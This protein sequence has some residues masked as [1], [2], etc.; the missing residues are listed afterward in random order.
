MHFWKKSLAIILLCVL[1]AVGIGHLT[2]DA[3]QYTRIT[4][5][6]V[7]FFT[8]SGQFAVGYKVYTIKAGTV[9]TLQT[10]WQDRLLTAPNTNPVILDSRGEAN[11]YTNTATKLV[12]TTPT[13]TLSSPIITVDYVGEQQETV[14]VNGNATAGTT[15]NNYV[16]NVTP[17]FLSIP[18]NLT[19]VMNPD[20]N[21]QETIGATI[22]TGSGINDIVFTGP[23]VGSTAG[24]IF[25]VETRGPGTPIAT[26]IAENVAAGLVTVGNHYVKLTAVT[27][28][29]ESLP[30]TASNVVNAA[31]A[32]KIDVSGIPAISGLITGYK[33]Y[34]TKAGGTDYYYVATV[35]ATTYT[36]SVADASLTVLAPSTQTATDWIR[37]K[38]DGG[39]WTDSVLLTA[40][41]QT[42]IEGVQ[43]QAAEI[44]GHV[45]GD[46]WTVTVMTPARLRFCSLT[47]DIIYENK[48]GSLVALDGN[49]M[50][51]GIPATLVR[52]TGVSGWVLNNPSLPV[53]TTQKPYRERKELT[54][55]YTVIST[56]IGKILS[57]TGTFA[58]N[59]PACATLP[60]H[61]W[62]I[63]NSGSGVITLTA[64]GTEK[65]KY[66]SDIT[67][68]TTRTLLPGQMVMI[69]TNGVDLQV[70]GDITGTVVKRTVLTSGTSFTTQS[71]TRTALVQLL[72]GGGGGGGV[73]SIVGPDTSIAGGGGSGAYGEKLFTV[74]PS[75]AYTYAIGAAGAAGSTGG[76]DGGNGGDTTFTVG[77]TTVTAPGGSGGKGSAVLATIKAGGAGGIV[78]TN[79]DVN[80]T[81]QPGDFGF[82]SGTDFIG[83][84]GGS[85]QFGSGG[86]AII[87][88]GAGNA[89]GGYG[90]GGGG[91]IEDGGAGQLG[92][93]GTAGLII[94]TEYN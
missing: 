89:A 72:G 50:V 77:A 9:D 5:P 1:A 70:A 29:G 92:G 45:V 19:V 59:W 84:K 37:W 10:T 56:D 26:T 44:I 33:V 61:W 17:T 40:A 32:R 46:I 94:V 3:T 54:G 74:S 22:H 36:I 65:F 39:S 57:C 79:G 68:S 31:G 7:Q 91:A 28:T 21:N 16:L 63:R 66:S 35:T 12:F 67:G 90:A 73:A 20:V 64:N 13:G 42:T 8:N 14:I 2:A 49:S 81:G 80:C 88:T 11:I 15:N 58:L 43:F 71:N 47:N 85:S 78:A 93:V 86:A 60:N 52:A 51:A 87:A 75:T 48:A 83:G 53:L 55:V 69:A 62:W 41:K 82:A 76:G 25:T 23:Y 27:A 4:Y 24:S 18:A 30:G 6:K 38:K 34:M